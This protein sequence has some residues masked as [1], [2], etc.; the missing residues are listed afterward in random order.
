[1]IRAINKITAPLRRGL[2][3][4]VGRGV[5]LGTDDNAKLKTAQV[6]LLDGEIRDGVEMFEQYGLTSN[7]LPLAEAVLV[8][9]GG[10]RDHLIAIANGD[11]RTRK[12]GL[13]PGEVAVYHHEGPSL[14]FHNGGSATLTVPTLTISATTVNSAGEWNHTGR[15]TASV[16]VLAQTVSL[17]GHKH[18]GG[19]IS[20][21]TDVPIGG[22]TGGGGGG[23]GG[24]GGG[25]S[26][27]D[28]AAAGS[29]LEGIA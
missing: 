16:D 13:V 3:L 6:K 10:N 15:F 23:G 11:R 24:S 25:I 2:K 26:T 27:G 7:P 28:G 12:N 18:L 5:I 14:V 29:Y 4:V 8:A 21:E 20:G 1:M 17:Y 22:G 19:T 9:V